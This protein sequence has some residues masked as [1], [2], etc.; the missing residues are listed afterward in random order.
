M[1]N[2]FIIFYFFLEALYAPANSHAARI[3]VKQFVKMASNQ[4]LC[5]ALYYYSK[6]P[7]A[8]IVLREIDKRKIN[9]TQI[10]VKTVGASQQ[11]KENSFAAAVKLCLKYVHQEDPYPWTGKPFDAY[12]SSPFHVHTYGQSDDY[13]E[14]S[15]CMAKHGEGLGE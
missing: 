8:D 2:S 5:V 11:Q 4:Q 14:F 15:K 10:I 1:K 12:V 3:E 9:C 7:N 13:F 6:M